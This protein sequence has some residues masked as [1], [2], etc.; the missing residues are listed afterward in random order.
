MSMTEE[1]HKIPTAKRYY[2]EHKDIII[3]RSVAYT[4]WKRENKPEE[5]KALKQ[6]YNRNYAAKQKALR[7]ANPVKRPLG[8][9][10]KKKPQEEPSTDTTATESIAVPKLRGRPRKYD[11][12]E[13]VKAYTP[14]TGGRPKKDKTQ[15][16]K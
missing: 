1:A 6:I 5:H 8:R 4:R 2:L 16:D 3:K 7:E 10:R 12:A 15:V 14:G 11:P 13:A 9:P